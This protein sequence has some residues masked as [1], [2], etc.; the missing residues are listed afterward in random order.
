[1]ATGKGNLKAFHVYGGRELEKQFTR[2]VRNREAFLVPPAL[3]SL[4]PKGSV[5]VPPARRVRAAAPAPAPAPAHAASVP[6]ATPVLPTTG[7]AAAPAPAAALADQSGS[8]SAA[9]AAAAAASA[10]ISTT[11]QQQK[12]ANHKVMLATNAEYMALLNST[13]FDQ[14]V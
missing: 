14:E 8:V 1:R 11:A 10:S 7:A 6:A 3:G 4:S 5:L 13:E 9:A 12:A 2:K